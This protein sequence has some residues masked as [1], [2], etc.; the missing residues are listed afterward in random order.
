MPKFIA[1]YRV[2]TARQGAS[3]LGLDAQRETVARFIQ[4]GELLAEFTEIESGKKH[5]NRPQLAAALADCKKRKATL[6]IAKLDRLARNV[7]FISGLMESKVEF[8]AVDMPVANRLTIHILAAVAEH[9]REMISQRTKA[10][11]SQAK[12]RG[13]R[14]GNPNLAAARVRAAATN[15]SP[16]S[17]EVIEFIQKMR[18]RGETFRAITAQLNDLHIKTGR[19]S[20][21]YP[22]TVRA[23]LLQ[24]APA[25]REEVIE[26]PTGT[27]SASA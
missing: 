11:L 9:E 10:A 23:L 27:Q 24:Q 12:L 26:Q 18:E 5:T 1:Y 15:Y 21:W 2:S 4:A 17:A 6:I 3:G 13:T 8:V 16:P 7:H 22:K 19:G 20:V 25:I 14:L